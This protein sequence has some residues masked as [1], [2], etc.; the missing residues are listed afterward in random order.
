MDWK[1]EFF[2]LSSAD[3]GNNQSNHSLCGNFIKVTFLHHKHNNKS[4]HKALP[5]QRLEYIHKEQ[6]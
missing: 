4:F 5:I 3:N 2:Q 6:Y 1:M